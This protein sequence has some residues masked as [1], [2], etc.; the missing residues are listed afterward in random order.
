MGRIPA[1]GELT[2][3]IRLLFEDMEKVHIIHDDVI[4]APKDTC[5]SCRG[6]PWMIL[7]Q[8]Y[9]QVGPPLKLNDVILSLIWR[10][11]L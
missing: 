9:M 6:I 10:P 1:S 8:W 7:S 4:S 5:S 3:S 2:K 11:K